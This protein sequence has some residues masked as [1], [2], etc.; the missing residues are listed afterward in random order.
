MIKH[1]CDKC[2]EPLKNGGGAGFHLPTGEYEVDV[3]I[4]HDGNP[5]LELCD[6]C[7]YSLIYS[8]DKR[9]RPAKE[10]RAED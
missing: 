4:T 7:I 5:N 6:D 8:T 2:G 10:A 3:S 9:P 1:F